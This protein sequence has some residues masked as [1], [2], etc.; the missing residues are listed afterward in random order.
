MKKTIYSVLMLLFTVLYTK[1]Q[2]TP[3]SIK[4]LNIVSVDVGSWI[5]GGSANFGYERIVLPRQAGYYSIK[6]SYGKWDFWDEKGDFLTITANFI[7]GK[8]NNHFEA[9]L[10]TAVLLHAYSKNSLLNTQEHVKF[11]PDVFCGYCFRKPAGHVVFKAG[12]G[13]PSIVSMGIGAAF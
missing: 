5:I 4:N 10:G 11:L 1:G 6:G 12:I 8:G 2:D 13:F 7:K 3:A 9:N